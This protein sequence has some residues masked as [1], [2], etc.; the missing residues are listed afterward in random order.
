MKSRFGLARIPWLV[1]LA[2]L[3]L[4]AGCDVSQPPSSQ[5]SAPSGTSASSAPIT[6]QGEVDRLIYDTPELMCG[7]TLVV[8]AGISAVGPSRWNT[9][10]GSRPASTEAALK[11]GYAIITPVQFS[12]MRVHVDHRT[13]PT[14]EFYTVGGKVGQD[15][16]SM[17]FPQV[18]SGMRY[19][20]VLLPGSDPEKHAFTPERLVVA[21]AFPISAK[22]IVTLAPGSI[23]QGIVTP[24]T[25]IPL[26]DLVQQLANCK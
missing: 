6:I 7:A 19:V 15:F 25:T 26:S 18:T 12:A 23:E 21:D 10:D 20:L 2:V 24:P 14:S 5:G 9:P 4:L 22:D 16:Y 13:Q 11:G 1:G 8:D 3:M 17:D